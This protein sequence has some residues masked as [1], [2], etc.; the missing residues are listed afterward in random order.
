MRP[1]MIFGGLVLVIAGIQLSV[2]DSFVLTPGATATIA[3]WTDSDPGTLPAHFRKVMIASTS[4]QHV[5]RPPRW[6]AW[7]ALSGGFVTVAL[8]MF[9]GGKK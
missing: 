6:I 1:A 3:E 7:C 9:S 5:V 8:T 2:V 4:P